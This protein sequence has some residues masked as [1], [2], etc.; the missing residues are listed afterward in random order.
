MTKGILILMAGLLLIS[1]NV[2]AQDD[3][4]I[5]SSGKTTTGVTNTNG[6]L[7]VTGPS[8]KSSIVGSASGTGASGVYGINNGNYGILGYDSYGVYGYSLGSWAGYFQGNARV[9]GNL[10]VDGSILGPVIG[11]ITG[12]TAGTG[13][14]GGGT[15]GDVTLNA[16]TAYLQRRVS[17][18]CTVGSSIRA[19]NADGTV[20]CQ[21]DSTGITSES[22]PEVGNNTTGFV[23]KWNGS[24]LVT[25]T[26]FDNGNVGIGTTNPAGNLDVNGDLCLSGVCRTT[27]PAGSG[28]G[29]FIDSGSLA[30]YNGGNVG[31]GT[32]SPQG[33]LNVDSRVLHMKHTP[34]PT[35]DS[36]V[37]LRLEIDGII[38]AGIMSG[39]NSSGNGGLFVGTL[40]NHRVGLGTNGIE[41]LTLATDGTLSLKGN[42]YISDN[43][44]IGTDTPS[45]KL[46]VS[47]SNT[48]FSS[49]TGDFR[50]FISKKID[51]D[52]SSI[53]FQ[54]NFS[55]RAELGLTLDDNF[56]IKVSPDGT[57]F[58][59]AMIVDRTSGNIAIGSSDT[60]HKLF[61]VASAE[62]TSA[63]W[64]ESSTNVPTLDV[65]QNGEGFGMRIVKA[66]VGTRAALYVLQQGTAP[67]LLVRN[68]VSEIMHL[69][70]NGNLG[71]G[72]DS[73]QS[74]LQVNGY[75]QLALISGIPPSQDCD[76][77]SELGRM[78]VD[79]AAGLL[80]ICMNS[81]WVAK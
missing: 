33:L 41:Q 1:L 54:N 66:A 50:L 30:Y 67:A 64:A 29:A 35:G 74:T 7:E 62:D 13:L 2:F 61:V 42:A 12:V 31:I 46:Q 80:Y 17:S 5:D 32:T 45:N 44:G 28:A 23:P 15:S 75:T 9:T 19:I 57:T 47:G 38:D 22:D 43:L 34:A 10:T 63:I 8:G 68:S 56:H 72:T 26:I 3:V 59:D 81:G 27:W 49:D 48:L 79:S 25:G 77:V 60:S 14:N 4:S 11:D 20:E 36:A 76:D 39:Y 69:D 16:D 18:S 53:I 70:S 78:K 37:G 40:S 6:H 71:I 73:P 21:T 51:T 52:I 55:G 58:T 24:A 65:R